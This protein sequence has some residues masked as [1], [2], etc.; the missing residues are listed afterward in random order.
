LY[1]CLKK[2][3]PNLEIQPVETKKD[4]IKQPA[5]AADENMWI[6]PL[7]SSVIICGKSGSGKTTLLQNYLTQTRFYKGWFKKTFIFSPTAGG[8]DIQKS[9]G[10]PKNRVFTDID[11]APELLEMILDSQKK[12]LENST[13]DKVDQFCIIFDDII[14]ETQFLNDRAFTK[15]FYQVRH[16]N[17]TT[18]ICTQHFY[19]VPKVCR[20]QAN[21]I[22]FFQGSQ[23][24]VDTIVEDYAP[25]LYTKREFETIV[26]EATAKPYS[27]L[28]VN[29]KTGWD[30]RF[31]Q[32]LDTVISL[33]RLSVTESKDT[34][35]VSQT[36]PPVSQHG[37][38]ES[39]SGGVGE[40]FDRRTIPKRAADSNW[41]V[42]K[43]NK[44]R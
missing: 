7:G 33:P 4:D 30:K 18:F 34:E 22:H 11:E 40:R 21:F 15:C 39:E 13:A 25:P 36:Q 41:D 27:F 6:P 17:C 38:K 42:Q 44:R 26:H 32:N 10:I 29:M 37:V 8:D 1:G 28:T 5:L 2:D 3:M 12:K 31:R 16:V 14:G 35:D 19:K 23:K 43:G 24:E 20:L 9:L